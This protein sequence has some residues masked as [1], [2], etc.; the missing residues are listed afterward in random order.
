MSY[1]VDKLELIREALIVSSNLCFEKSG[2]YKNWVSEY[3]KEASIER[4]KLALRLDKKL[5]EKN[6][7]YKY[8]ELDMI[9]S[10]LI[11]YSIEIK[12][13]IKYYDGKI[14]EEFSK[15]CKKKSLSDEILS[16]LNKKL[17]EEDKKN[18]YCVF[19]R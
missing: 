5:F 17:Y 11:D 10:A 16:S 15:F 3:F 7:S 4:K 19:E 13:K 8:D 9:R 6:K 14:S 1:M 18:G 12:S 2:W